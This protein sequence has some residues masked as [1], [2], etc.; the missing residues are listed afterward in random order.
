MCGQRVFAE[1][2]AA[3]SLI[4]WCDLGFM[5]LTLSI[6]PKAVKEYQKLDDPSRKSMSQTWVHEL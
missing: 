6:D 1:T 5:S 3:A 4:T 2:W